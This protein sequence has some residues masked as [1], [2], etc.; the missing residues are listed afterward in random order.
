MALLDLDQRFVEANTKLCE[1]LGHSAV[2]LG[3]R[4]LDDVTHPEDV[5]LDEALIAAL[6]AGSRR[7][8]EIV[9][10]LVTNEGRSTKE[11]R[12]SAWRETHPAT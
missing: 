2:E 4:T 3:Q 1:M 11:R 9:K 6:F 10:R 12:R 8:Y 5:G 7:H